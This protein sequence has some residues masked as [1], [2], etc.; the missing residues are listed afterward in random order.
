[1]GAIKTLKDKYHYQL[2]KWRYRNRSITRAKVLYWYVISAGIS[3][4][5][6]GV[7]CVFTGLP[8]YYGVSPIALLVVYFVLYFI[9]KNWSLIW[10]YIKDVDQGKLLLHVNTNTNFEETHKRKLIQWVYLSRNR[11]RNERWLLLSEKVRIGEKLTMEETVEYKSKVVYLPQQLRDGINEAILINALIFA[12]LQ[13]HILDDNCRS[14]LDLTDAN[15]A[16]FDLQK[17]IN[18]CKVSE[19]QEASDKYAK[20]GMEILNK[21]KNG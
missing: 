16:K 4:F 17:E 15:I 19:A 13:I 1:M 7:S 3:M 6:Y 18:R 12:H 21:K 2:A 8:W 20:K 10:I 9:R 14:I 11:V 5:M